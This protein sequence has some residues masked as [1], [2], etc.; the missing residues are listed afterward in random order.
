M[1]LVKED[2]D[3]SLW[4]GVRNVQTEPMAL[5]AKSWWEC[6]KG[7]EDATPS[8]SPGGKGVDLGGLESEENY[9]PQLSSC[10]SSRSR[11]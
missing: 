5:A 4:G 8:P 9:G 6:W 2:L 7:G 3:T 11:A 1:W 10:G